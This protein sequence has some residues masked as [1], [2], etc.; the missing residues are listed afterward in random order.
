M[1]KVLKTPWS[2]IMEEAAKARIRCPPLDSGTTRVLY[3]YRR[4]T[5]R[6]Y[7]IPTAI[8]AGIMR[9]ANEFLGCRASYPDRPSGQDSGNG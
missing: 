3:D 9:A 4:I 2:T 6:L 5:C 8:A 7:S 1:P